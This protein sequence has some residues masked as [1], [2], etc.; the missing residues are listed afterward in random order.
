MVCVLPVGEVPTEPAVMMPMIF[1]S[2]LT[3]EP[4][5]S[6]GWIWASVSMRPS[7]CS[8]V[9]FSLS[10]A[11]MDLSRPVTLPAATIGL[12]LAPPALPM[13][14]TVSPTLTVEESPNGAGVMPEA[15]RSLMTAMSRE[16][17]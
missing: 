15:L 2:L 7:S 6:P 4:P 16:A 13:P 17:S 3:S 14:M 10:I 5:E 1:A 11:V 12:P 8:D 9:P